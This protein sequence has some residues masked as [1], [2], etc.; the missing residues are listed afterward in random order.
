MH[1]LC[2]NK[3]KSFW[4]GIC[5]FAWNNANEN[6]NNLTRRDFEFAGAMGVMTI[7]TGVLY[8]IDFFWVVYQKAL[9][10]DDYDA[11][12]GYYK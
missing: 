5:C 10:G 6:N 12:E 3:E 11:N 1:A 4:T 2:C 8:L 9:I 7:A